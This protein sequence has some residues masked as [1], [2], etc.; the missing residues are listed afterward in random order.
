MLGEED[1]LSASLV[2]RIQ[3]QGNR[4]DTELEGD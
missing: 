4:R 1:P 2:L 3:I